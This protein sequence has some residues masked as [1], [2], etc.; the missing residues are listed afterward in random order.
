MM[1]PERVT[2]LTVWPTQERADA[3]SGTP[4][5]KLPENEIR[6]RFVQTWIT[7]TSPYFYS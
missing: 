2:Y 6:W 4:P 1:P 5:Q 7:A 3:G